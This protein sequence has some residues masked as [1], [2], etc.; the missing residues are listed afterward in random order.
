MTQ[1]GIL[2]ADQIAA[3][4]RDGFVHVPGFYGADDMARITAWTEEVAD[5]PEQPG[6]H[7]V[8]HEDSLRA[9]GT[10]V[11]QRIED[12]TPF[13]AGFRGLFAEGRMP[14]AV[15]ELLGERATLFKDK[16]SSQKLK[17]RI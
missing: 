16:I 13:H 2:T 9:P 1:P 10:R 3:F 8:Y 17:S 4:H 12:V 7:M 6:R 11:V 5:W 14:G 15:S